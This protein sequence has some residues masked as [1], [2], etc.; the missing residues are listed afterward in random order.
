MDFANR[1]VQD[2]FLLCLTAPCQSV[3]TA[4]RAVP[5]RA[6]E[7][8]SKRR[9]NKRAARS[10]D[11]ARRSDPPHRTSAVGCPRQ[12]RPGARAASA[13]GRAELK[14]TRRSHEFFW[15]R[16]AGTSKQARAWG[17]RPGSTHARNTSRT[18]HRAHC[19]VLHV[20][21]SYCST[22]AAVQVQHRYRSVAVR[23]GPDRA[24]VWVV[25]GRAERG[26]VVW[27]RGA[28][29]GFARPALLC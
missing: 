24:R 29:S 20:T 8:T 27:A 19:Y 11:A 1:F 7:K 6:K 15:Q 10:R 18:E 21:F 14:P 23:L 13:V 2:G 9:G 25:S 12:E 28:M 22:L 17:R 4:R 3:E 26:G 16:R 5:C